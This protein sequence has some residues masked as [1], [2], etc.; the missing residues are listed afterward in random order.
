MTIAAFFDL[1]GTLLPPPSLERRYLHHL[2]WRGDLRW[3]HWLRAALH[4]LPLAVRANWSWET[5]DAGEGEWAVLAANNKAHLQGIPSGTMEA[6]CAWLKGYRLPV[7]PAAR[8]RIEWHVEQGHK[9][10]LATGAPAP[11]VQGIARALHPNLEIL[12][13]T[14]G[15]AGGAFTG[16][17]TGK[18]MAGIEKSRAIAW[19][20]AHR[21]LTL[22]DCFAYGDSFADRWMLSRVGHPVAVNPCR[23]LE[24]LARKSGWPIARWSGNSPAGQCG[25]LP[26]AEARFVDR[27][28]KAAT[29]RGCSLTVFSS[30]KDEVHAAAPA[31]E[32]APPKSASC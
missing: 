20:A 24:R 7:F 16:R 14:L 22:N 23:A 4:I 2:K 8:R 3:R 10:F 28:R 32:T 15:T 25:H 29:Q 17:V 30:L 5:R 9:I 6:F 12:A 11:L 27:L 19:L 26:P 21:R 18:A 31:L 1:D 13:T